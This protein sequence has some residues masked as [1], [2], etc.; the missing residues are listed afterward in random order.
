M[1]STWYMLVGFTL[2]AYLG[3]TSADNK[4]PESPEKPAAVC[5]CEA[6]DCCKECCEK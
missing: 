6:C 3:V 1:S 5:P 4:K 2:G